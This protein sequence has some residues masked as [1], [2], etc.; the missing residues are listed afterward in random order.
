MPFFIWSHNAN[1]NGVIDP[2]INL[3]EGMS[4]SAVNDSCRAV[5]A[6]LAEYRDDIAG[7]IVTAGTST[8]YTLASNQGFDTFAHLNNMVVAFSPHVTNTGTAC[9]LNVDG[10]GAKPLRISPGIETPAGTIVQGTPYVALYNSANNEFYLVGLSGAPYLIPLGATLDYWLPT[11][12]SSAYVFPFGQAISRT[13]YATLF[14]GMGTTFGA[15]NGTTTFNIPDLRGRVVASP[16]NMGGGVDP[17]RLTS[18]PSM[19]L[20]RNSLGGGGGQGGHQLTADE[21]P[22]ITSAGG[23]V[24]CSGSISATPDAGSMIIGGGSGLAG[25]PGNQYSGNNHITGTFAG[26][27]AGLNVQSTNTL[28]GTHENCQATILGNRIMRIL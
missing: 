9:T 14:A 26:S 16:D 4:P 25:G 13:T 8:A 5:M 19:A 23:G 3:A 7:A 10:L 21:I 2:S 17:N 22:T 12:P 18:S 6:R 24:A 28:N 1:L 20:V 27:T 11:A 15:G